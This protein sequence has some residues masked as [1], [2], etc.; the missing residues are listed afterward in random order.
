M[1][2]PGVSAQGLDETYDTPLDSFFET[3]DLNQGDETGSRKI[4]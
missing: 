1:K 2:K 3:L 4:A